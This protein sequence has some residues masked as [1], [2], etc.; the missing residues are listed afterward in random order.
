MAFQLPATISVSS[1]QPTELFQANLL[2]RIDANAWALALAISALPVSLFLCEPARAEVS[3]PET[4]ALILAYAGLAMTGVLA[5][6]SETVIMAW[7][8]ADGLAFLILL[9]S[10]E[11]LSTVWGA[12]LRYLAH[13]ASIGFVLLASVPFEGAIYAD[14]IRQLAW[15]L[16]VLLRIGL[17]P[18]H[19][20][21][22]QMSAS[23][24]E[25]GVAVRLLPPAMGLAFLSRFVAGN[26]P[27][28]LRWPLIILGGLS[29][30]IGGIRWAISHDP[31]RSRP[32]FVLVL[33]GV[34]VA[35][36]AGAN[37]SGV[38]SIAFG[39]MLVLLG[40]LLSQLEIYE[41]WH[42]YLASGAALAA[43]G[44][45]WTIGHFAYT[46]FSKGNGLGLP[47]L[48]AWAIVGLGLSL[49]AL[50][51]SR[52]VIRQS[53]SW[54]SGGSFVRNAYTAGV[55]LPLVILLMAGIR[56]GAGPGTPS[57][58]AFALDGLT[59][60][61]GWLFL[62]SDHG[63]VLHSTASRMS[64]ESARF[65]AMISRSIGTAMEGITRFMRWLGAML[66]GRAALLWV[67]VALL[68]LVLFLTGPSG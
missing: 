17:W 10:A 15:I 58:L 66:E 7:A 47:G 29:V 43:L 11:R 5:A 26:V 49:V 46:A 48:V 59:S 22:P 60:G 8:L 40:V 62:Q 65:G 18:L 27:G 20:S 3:R 25:L 4:R 13:L 9:S 56:L 45:P 1:W 53:A 39:T 23:L 12:Y 42:R 55:F 38:I 21:M 32:F 30:L 64:L 57:V 34:S 68:I 19:I 41:Q 54:S 50:G 28:G 2:L 61:G 33:A 63:Q 52:S 44:F 16:A 14:W 35:G 31:L 36:V 51:I 67:Y 24:R 6:N 37:Q